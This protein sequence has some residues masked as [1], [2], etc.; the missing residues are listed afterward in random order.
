MGLLDQ[1]IAQVGQSLGNNQGNVPHGDVVTQL[2]KSLGLSNGNGIAGLVQ[3][4]QQHGL[5]DMIASWVSQG[6]NPPVSAGQVTQVL[7]ADKLG[8]IA[9]SLGVSPEVAAGHVSSVLPSLIDK[10]TPTGQ[11]PQG[12]LLTEGLGI[13]KN[14]F[15][16]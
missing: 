3:L 10:L 16:N 15:G 12:D 9:A 13:L 7:G 6:P 2:V 1:L 5:G 4:F 14:L 11:V 8:Q